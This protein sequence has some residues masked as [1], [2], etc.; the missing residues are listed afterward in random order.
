[1]KYRVLVNGANGKMGRLACTT[2][3]NHPDFKLVGRVGRGDDLARRLVLTKAQIVVDL[4]RADCVYENSLI[5][6]QQGVSPVIGTSGLQPEQILELQAQCTARALGG[7]V[8]P[9]FSISA[10]LMMRFSAQAAHY[11]PNVEIRSEE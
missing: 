4:T 11:L 3:A 6:I 5:M 10:V 1:M 7:I 2:L 9:N 8:V